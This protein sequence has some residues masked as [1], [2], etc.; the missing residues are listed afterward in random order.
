[1][2]YDDGPNPT[3][4][5]DEA[6]LQEIRDRYRYACDAW[7]EIREERKID[8]RY[9]SGDPWDESDRKARADAGRP[10]INHDEL[11]QYVNQAINGLRQNK[12]G[13]KVSPAGNGASE[14]TAELHQDL[15]RT[16]EYRSQAQ[17]AYVTA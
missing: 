15:I 17:S 14:K 9:I 3:L 6:L 8:M 13:I 12:R 16:I 2:P 7:R 1:M 4:T 10:C 11:G 5:G